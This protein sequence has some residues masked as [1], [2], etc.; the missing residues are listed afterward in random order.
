VNA[1]D[2]DEAPFYDLE[3]ERA[4][5]LAAILQRV[6]YTLW[7]LA[8]CEDAA[9]HYLMLRAGATKGM[10]EIAGRAALQKE[11]AKTFGALL[12]ELRSNG[13]VEGSLEARLNALLRERNWLVHRSKRESRGVINDLDNV[14]VL[15]ARLDR[16]AE[17]AT[18]L[19]KELAQ[20]I[21]RFVVSSGVDPSFIDEEA[22]KLAE[23][24]GY[25]A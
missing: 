19:D 7:Q 25:E 9:A 8:E 1:N 21:E 5:L 20:R 11:Q 16:I 2:H 18:T 4:G 24:W 23:S 14:D 12:S 15:V 6:G 22:K 17:E 13:I 10:G 3:I